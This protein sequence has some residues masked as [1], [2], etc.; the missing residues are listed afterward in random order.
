MVC[1][2]VESLSVGKG[3]P[4]VER[5]AIEAHAPRRVA[6]LTGGPHAFGALTA[7]LRGKHG[8]GIVQQVRKTVFG[9]RFISRAAQREP[10]GMPQR[11]WRG[12]ADPVEHVAQHLPH[13][14]HVGCDKVDQTQSTALRRHRYARRSA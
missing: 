5:L 7:Q 3:S 10:L 8:G 11:R 9:V 12:A 2:M 13:R 6:L 14:L 4:S 1:I